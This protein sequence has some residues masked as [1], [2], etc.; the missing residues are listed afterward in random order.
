MMITNFNIMRSEIR[1][2]KANQANVLKSIG[3]QNMK[4]ENHLLSPINNVFDSSASREDSLVLTN[5][6]IVY[7]ESDELKLI[8]GYISDFY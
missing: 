4:W 7:R 6:H 8:E 5:K 1:Y 2:I 3:M